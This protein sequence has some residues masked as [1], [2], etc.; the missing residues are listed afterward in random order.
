MSEFAN[1]EKAD[2]HLIYGAA[3]G[4]GRAALRLYQE[5]FRNR[6]MWK[7]TMFERLDRSLCEKGSIAANSDIIS[8]T[9]TVRPHERINLDLVL[10][11]TNEF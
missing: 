1:S 8:G 4:N 10:L 2:V 11:Y 7:H 3:N 6:C 5:L 9:R